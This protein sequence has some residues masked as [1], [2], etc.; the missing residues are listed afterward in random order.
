MSTLPFKTRFLI[1]LVRCLHQYGASSYR[2]EGAVSSVSQDL[3]LKCDLFSGVTSCFI[4]IREED[5]EDEQTTTRV[6]RLEPGVINLAR[7]S[8]ADEIANR[9]TAGELTAAQGAQMLDNIEEQIPNPKPIWQILAYGLTGAGVAA[10]FSGSWWDVLAALCTGWVIGTLATYPGGLGRQGSLDAVAAMAA[11]MCASLLST[12]LPGLSPEIVIIA[13][14]IVLMPGLSLTT[15]MAELGTN[16]LVSGSARLAGAM[17][18]LLKLTFGVVLGN[19]LMS[20]LNLTALPGD[21]S[22]TPPWFFWIALL[23]GGWGSA[24]LFHVRK[25]DMPAALVAAVLGYAAAKYATE[26]MGADLGIFIAGLVVAS[27]SNLFARLW[28]RPASVVRVP[29]IILLVPGGLGFRGIIQVFNKDALTSLDTGM[30]LIVV[31]ASLVAGLLFGNVL[32]QPRR[33]L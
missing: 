3:K 20:F 7:L 13:G 18:T 30:S 1:R 14:L 15:A 24:Y 26:G 23:M 25:R 31:L 29:G 12:V 10:L 2:L 22:P 19:Y 17:M 32:I 33:S 21:P 8:L 27:F 11:A 4:S 6:L 9:V 28:Q 5:D 16:H